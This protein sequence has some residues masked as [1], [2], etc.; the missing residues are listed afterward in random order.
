MRAWLSAVAMDDPGVK[1]PR[2]WPNAV[3]TTSTMRP[4][5]G[6]GTS[7]EGGGSLFKV[8]GRGAGAADVGRVELNSNLVPASFCKVAGTS[9]AG[10]LL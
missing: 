2:L 9:T 7:K 8:A 5:F 1:Y 10:R 3:G 4:F 6:Q